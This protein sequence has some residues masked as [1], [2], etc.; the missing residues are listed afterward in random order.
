MA[1]DR[2]AGQERAI[3]MAVTWL[4]TGRLPHAILV[5]GPAGAGKRAFALALA[6]AVLCAHAEADA[7]G[8]CRSCL[9]LDAM[10]HP[11]LHALVPLVAAKGPR[12]EAGLQEEMREAAVGFLQRDA[13]VS[14]SAA[15]IAREHVRLL[16][17]Q[18]SLAPV[19]GSRRV[20][21][22]L[23]A[24]RMHPAAGNSL[25]KT[26]E[27]PTPTSLFILVSAAPDQIMPTIRSRCQR[28][29]LQRLRPERIRAQLLAD[30]C[31][32]ERVELGVRLSGGSLS[33]ARAAARGDLEGVCG[34]VERLLRGALAADDEAYWQFVNEY[35]A[36]DVRGELESVLELCGLY[37]RD[38]FMTAGGPAAGDAVP[39]RGGLLAD[40]RARLTAAQIETAALELD[41][42]AEFLRH[43]VHVSLALAGLWGCLGG[44]RP[45]LES[46]AP[47]PS[48]LSAQWRRAATLPRSAR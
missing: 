23:D 30:G 15:S 14:S 17:R 34:A 42:A 7:C 11:D 29:A 26:L 22:I 24:E 38:A 10:G 43:N 32:P 1:F 19:M 39:D 33:R 21:I 45:P 48:G 44:A 47:L 35:G 18:M 27:E 6:K 4:Q 20:A 12:D 2:F 5:V 9:L 25:L 3:Q 28:L 40:L 37:L 13:G 16:Q 31:E 36:R 8:S 41:R 46:A